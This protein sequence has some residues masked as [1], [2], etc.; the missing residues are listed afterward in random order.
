MLDRQFICLQDPESGSFFFEDH[1]LRGLE[2][3]YHKRPNGLPT[4]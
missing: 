1:P 2:R 3:D 4:P